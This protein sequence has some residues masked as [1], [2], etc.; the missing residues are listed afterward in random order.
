MECLITLTK[1]Q[2]R[3]YSRDALSSGLPLVNNCLTPSLF[4]RAAARAGLTAK[5]VRRPIPKISNFVLPA[6]LILKDNQ[7]VIM[8][9]IDDDKER[10]WIT[11]PETGM[12][13]R[14]MHRAELEAEYSGIA[15]FV[16]PEFVYDDRTRAPVA[17]V[18]RHWFWS[19]L[20]DSWRIYRDVLVA[21]LL[22][23]IFAL[24]SPLFMMNVYDRVVPNNAEET[25]WVLAIGIT[26]VYVFDILIKMLRGYFIDVAGK[27]TDIRV[28]SA[29][30]ERVMGI[31][32]SARPSSVGAFANNL[33]EFEAVRD[34]ITSATITTLIDLPFIII[35]L[36]VINWIGGPLVLVP[37]VTIP[38]IVIYALLAQKP[39]R[40]AT[41][42]TFRAS[43]QKNAT[44]IE[45]LTGIETVKFL[46]AEG[47]LQRKWEQ[48][49]AHI[50]RWSTKSRLISSSTVNFAAAMQQLT[51]VGIVVFGVYL[52]I[53]GE[54]S[55]G[56]LIACVILTGRT[57]APMGQV[58]NLSTRY[59]QART[60]LSSLNEIMQ[61]PVERPAGSSFL[62]RPK[63]TGNIEFDNVGFTYP[64][65]DNPSLRGINFRIKQ[66]ERVGIIGRI[67][68]GKT[69]INKLIQGMYH[70]SE[71]AVRVDGTDIRQIDP[72]DVRRNIGYVPQD[73]TLFFGSVREN[74]TYGAP[75][76]DDASVLR[77][78]QI[79]GVTDFVDR[80]PLGFD[81][82]V[83]ERGE[84][85]SGGQRQAVAVARALLTDPSILLLDEPSNSMDNT[86]EELV[87][88]QLRKIMQD[89]TLIVVTHRASLLELVDRLIIIDKGRLVADGPKEKVLEALREGRIGMG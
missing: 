38:L 15:I 23:N 22:I 77:A 82:P 48:A 30:Y 41:E 32:M 24:A 84:R 1:L 86:S 42:N 45:S 50:A 18:G 33:R 49:V 13:T 43:A 81:M 46:G 53:A 71:G 4:V 36:V 83:G 51:T 67:G 64:G 59:F 17:A 27:K 75:Y 40:Q 47:P 78:A 39:L 37:A 58:A 54:L 14:I 29:I 89:K 8:H 66:G 72:A 79:A 74:I 35:F 28:S 3:P 63:L 20:G 10:I 55:M 16:Q 65:Q 73:I 61:L 60:A 88:A 9:R 62:S 26:T 5:I 56:G 12:G 11:N 76:M 2:H 7:A 68:S 57:M 19:V 87:R 34:F 31:K 85:L 6:V 70:A 44:L 69:T 21:S 80:H 25:L 52:I